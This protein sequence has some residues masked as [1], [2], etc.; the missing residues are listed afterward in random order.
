M[1]VAVL[2]DIHGNLPA[3]DA[4][5]DDI[6][7]V[8]VDA[9]VLNGDLATGPMPAET[10]DRL[11]ELGE[12]ATWVRGNADRELV[13]AYDGGLNADLPEAVRLPTEYGASR[14]GSRH[15]DLLDGLPLSVAL[16]V[17]GFGPVRVGRCHGAQRHRD[18]A[19]RLAGKPLPRRVLRHRRADRGAGAYAH[20]VRPARRSPSV[21]EPG[22]CGNALRSCGR[23]LGATRSDGRP[24]PCR[25]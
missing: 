11:A 19:R 7:A 5:L 24:A 12:M 21:R 25:L 10:L 8:A 1:R 16:D 14:L 13:A 2:A 23:A 3:L 20:A 22:Q 15:R 18:R 6:D 9:I 17:T 4:V